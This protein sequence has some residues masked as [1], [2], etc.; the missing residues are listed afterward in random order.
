M[1]AIVRGGL[2]VIGGVA[3]NWLGWEAGSRIVGK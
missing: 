3:A 1:G 2:K